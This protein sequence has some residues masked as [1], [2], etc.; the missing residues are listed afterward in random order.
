[1]L[2]KVANYIT[3]DFA[4]VIISKGCEETLQEI[5]TVGLPLLINLA[6]IHVN[7]QSL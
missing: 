6:K 1:M 3:E 5:S 4:E 7:S 2:I